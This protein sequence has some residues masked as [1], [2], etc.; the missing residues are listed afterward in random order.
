MFFSRLNAPLHPEGS[1]CINDSSLKWFAINEEEIALYLPKRVLLGNPL[2]NAFRV[3][4]VDV[5]NYFLSNL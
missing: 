2:P 3:I 1:V 5:P 4:Y